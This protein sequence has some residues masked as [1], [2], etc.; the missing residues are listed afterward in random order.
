MSLLDLGT[1]AGLNLLFDDYAYAYRAAEGEPHSPRAPDSGVTLECIARNDLEQLPSSACP[2]WRR[3]SAST[4]PR[5]TALRRR[6][7]V[8]AGLPV[9]RQPTRFG[10]LRAALANVRAAAKPPAWSAATW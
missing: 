2:P 6:R 9:A 10:R 7:P 4:S 3:G 1:S 8:A 5:S